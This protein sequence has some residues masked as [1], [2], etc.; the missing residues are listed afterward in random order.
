MDVRLG[1]EAESGYNLHVK[2]TNESSQPI[3][4]GCYVPWGVDGEATWFR[5]LTAKTREELEPDLIRASLNRAHV[6]CIKRTI[7]PKAVL[8]G[9][10]SLT[11]LY[12]KIKEQ[13][14]V[15]DWWCPQVPQ[16]RCREQSGAYITFITFPNDGKPPQMISKSSISGMLEMLRE[17]IKDLPTPKYLDQG[18]MRSLSE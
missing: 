12:P 6:P 11:K 4:F 15:I 14:V 9:I 13:G 1:G 10:N 3:L 18:F 17:L 16:V 5:A 7:P 2:L 8:E